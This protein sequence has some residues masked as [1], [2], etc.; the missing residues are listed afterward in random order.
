MDFLSLSMLGSCCLG[1]GSGKFFPE[2]KVRAVLLLPGEAQKYCYSISGALWSPDA[3]PG[4]ICLGDVWTMMSQ[5]YLPVSQLYAVAAASPHSIGKIFVKG[6]ISCT[7]G[8]LI[9]LSNTSKPHSSSPGFLG[10]S[11]FLAAVTVQQIIKRL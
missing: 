1:R 2:G 3:K 7:P 8:V 4:D 6:W 9:C 5:Y 11:C 10:H